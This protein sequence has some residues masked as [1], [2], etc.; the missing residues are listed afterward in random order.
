MRISPVRSISCIDARDR[1][2]LDARSEAAGHRLVREG[3]EMARRVDVRRTRQ[4]HLRRDDRRIHRRREEDGVSSGAASRRSPRTS[5]RRRPRRCGNAAGGC[6]GRRR[7]WRTRWIR[8]RPRTWPPVSAGSTGALRQ[9]GI[10][11]RRRSRIA[12]GRGG[13]PNQ[14]KASACS[15]RCATVPPLRHV[16][17]DY[18]PD[19]TKIATA[20]TAR[21]S[22]IDLSRTKKSIRNTSRLWWR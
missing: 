9:P 13:A 1:C 19:L 4:Q 21:R 12:C 14:A 15:A 3:L 20:A 17:K 6:A 11:A 5:S 22:A 2:Q 16:G 18:A 10:S 8:R 7:A